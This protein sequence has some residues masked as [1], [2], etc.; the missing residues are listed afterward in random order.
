MPSKLPPSPCRSILSAA[1]RVAAAA[2]VALAACGPA[3]ASG[4]G[5][6]KPFEVPIYHTDIG[7]TRHFLVYVGIDGGVPKPYLLDTGSPNMFA[8]YGAWWPGRTTL[9]PG[10]GKHKIKFASGLVYHYDVVKADV[11]LG[12]RDG[13]VMARAENVAIARITRVDSQ[14]PRQ[15]FEAW[16]R[17]DRAGRPP[18]SDGT[19]GNFGAALH[20][21][22]TLATV[23]AQVRLPP[24]LKNGFVVRSGGRN[25]TRGKLVIGLTPAMIASFPWRMA[26]AP[27][28][29]LLPNPDGNAHPVEAY[30]K[31]QVTTTVVRLKRGRDSFVKSIPTVFD[32]GGGDS[33]WIYDVDIP[34]AFVTGGAAYGPAR[35]GVSFSLE[36]GGSEILAYAA[37]DEPASDQL[38][39]S[40]G[41]DYP[42]VNPGILMFYTWDV[43]FDLEDG[44]LG[45]RPAGRWNEE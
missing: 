39:F 2:I 10:R 45:L 4:K 27:N 35:P 14:T 18:F 6:A 23:V 28:G 16:K 26:M 9:E 5:G 31:A 24:G 20:G 12:A 15:S 34:P 29:N 17:R 13:R 42:R 33:T 1:R 19:Y 7:G 36:N 37:G 21:S 44:L 3:A 25:A 11:A 40:T 38:S 41:S 22:S 32:T 43:M 8:T 30:Q